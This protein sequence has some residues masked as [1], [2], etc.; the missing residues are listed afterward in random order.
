VAERGRFELIHSFNLWISI[1]KISG[2]L[3]NFL[4]FYLKHLV[5]GTF[6]KKGILKKIIY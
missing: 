1:Q 5:C 3:D 4:S 2:S 6:R